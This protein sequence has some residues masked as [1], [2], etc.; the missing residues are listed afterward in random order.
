[1]CAT[2]YTCPFASAVAEIKPLVTSLL[3]AS[4]GLLGLEVQRQLE[5]MEDTIVGPEPAVNGNIAFWV[6]N[7]MVHRRHG[8]TCLPDFA[9]DVLTATRTL[10]TWPN[11][12]T[13]GAASLKVAV[14]GDEY[15]QT[16][17]PHGL[18]VL[19]GVTEEWR[20]DALPF[21]KDADFEER[22]GTISRRVPPMVVLDSPHSSTHRTSLRRTCTPVLLPTR[23]L[24]LGRQRGRSRQLCAPRSSWPGQVHCH[25]PR[26]VPLAC[27]ITIGNVSG[28]FDEIIAFDGD[29][30]AGKLPTGA[31]REWCRLV[32]GRRSTSI[33][34]VLATLSPLRRIPCRLLPS[35]F[36]AA[37]MCSPRT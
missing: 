11:R 17:G 12:G 24:L 23:I 4:E 9:L 31:V 29:P 37:K 25:H 30:L 20:D 13:A 10:T 28:S 33:M 5:V 8:G 7:T 1:M 19:P 3:A 14:D 26:P 2:T 36:D 15:D 6:S 27:A 18:A 35:S 16:R 32:P 22:A 34:G 21:L